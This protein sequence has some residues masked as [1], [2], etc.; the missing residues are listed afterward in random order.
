MKNHHIK[1][2][3][4]DDLWRSHF[5]DF[6]WHFARNSFRDFMNW[7]HFDGFQARSPKIMKLD[8]QRAWEMFHLTWWF[9]VINHDQSSFPNFSWER[10]STRAHNLKVLHP[11]IG[12]HSMTLIKVI[13]KVFIL[14]HTKDHGNLKITL[15]YKR[16]F[17]LKFMTQLSF[18]IHWSWCSWITDP[19]RIICFNLSDYEKL[20]LY[21]ADGDC[22]LTPYPNQAATG[23]TILA[24]VT[25]QSQCGQQCLGKYVSYVVTP[26]A[27]ASH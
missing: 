26:I 12:H 2:N 10:L 16:Y 5:Y 3:I 4:F 20:I 19:K 7:F 24:A 13:L 15:N 11:A 1:W 27:V 23:G 17:L 21:T 8:H 22:S 9:L 18:L 25:S 6:L 14:L